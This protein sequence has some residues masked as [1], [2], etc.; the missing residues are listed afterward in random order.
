MTLTTRL[1]ISAFDD[2]R[3]AVRMDAPTAS[4]ILVAWTRSHMSCGVVGLED[5]E[6]GAVEIPPSK[7]ATLTALLPRP[8]D[9]SALRLMYPEV[10]EGVDPGQVPEA[11]RVP[12]MLRGPGPILLR[13][14]VDE[15]AWAAVTDHVVEQVNAGLWVSDDDVRDALYSVLSVPEL[16][17]AWMD[18]E[19]RKAAPEVPGERVFEPVSVSDETGRTMSWESASRWFPIADAAEAAAD[20]AN[21]LAERAQRERG[22]R[23]DGSMMMT[24]RIS[25][26]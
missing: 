7:L 11:E 8:V 12:G 21:E 20:L 3:A 14:Q 18:V 1:A 26:V 10:L 23:G 2:L 25:L 4:V 24:Y 17:S 22:A 9:E 16:P 13:V 19:R 6:G 5:D 15:P